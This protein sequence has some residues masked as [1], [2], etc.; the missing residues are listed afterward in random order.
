MRLSPMPRRARSGPLD[1]ARRAP[2]S[3]RSL[4]LHL[5]AFLCVLLALVASGLLAG[6]GWAL[7]GVV[8]WGVIALGHA[9]VVVGERQALGE[10]RYTRNY[11]DIGRRWG[12]L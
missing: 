6:S 2:A 10:P 5:A 1:A 3:L 8:V 11:R 12:G 4:L 9:A 7:G